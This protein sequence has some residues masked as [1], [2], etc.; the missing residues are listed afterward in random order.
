MALV[1]KDRVQETTTTTGTG[2]LTLNGAV[3]G[4]QSFSVIGDGNTTYYSIVYGSDF[5]VGIG[6]YTSSGTTL[7]RNTILS[8]SN[9]NNAVNFGSGTKNVFVTYPASKSVNLDNS[10]NLDLTG[11]P[12][13]SSSNGNI[14]L[15]PNGTGAVVLDGLS[16]PTADGTVSQFLKTNGSGVL[17]FATQG[18]ITVNGNYFSNYNVI[19]EDCTTTVD[20]SQNAFLYGPITVNSGFTWTI[21][22]GSTLALVSFGL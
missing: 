7:S 12:I 18:I 9:S 8:S 16:Y 3:T 22:S 20:S 19:T 2:T 17:S 13:V 21:A 14:L 6:T 15:T 4:F 11:V 1:L 10:N 5:E